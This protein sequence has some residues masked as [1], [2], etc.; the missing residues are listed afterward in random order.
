MTAGRFHPE[1]LPTAP[2][3]FGGVGIRLIGKGTWR[4]ALCPFHDDTRASLRVLSTSGAFKCMACNARGGDVLAF[5]RLRTGKRFID[6]AR[7]LGAWG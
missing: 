4:S 7:A 5:E 6:A 2:E 3:Y 1:W